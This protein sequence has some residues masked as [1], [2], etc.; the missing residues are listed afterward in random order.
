MLAL[1]TGHTQVAAKV[2]NLF[3][4][5]GHLVGARRRLLVLLGGI[6]RLYAGLVHT[7]LFLQAWREKELMGTRAREEDSWI[8]VGATG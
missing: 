3:V 6:V 7:F 2:E 5:L 8:S 4:V 1:A